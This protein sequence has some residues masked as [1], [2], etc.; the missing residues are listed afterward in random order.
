M[1]LVGARWLARLVFESGARARPVGRCAVLIAGLGAGACNLDNPGVALPAGTVAFPIGLALSGEDDAGAPRFLYVANA[2]FDLNYNA[3]SVQSYD[4]EE[5]ARRID[6][7]DGGCRP[8]AAELPPGAGEQADAGSPDAEASD[9]ALDG[10]LP[11]SELPDAEVDGDLP[12]GDVPDAELDA[13]VDSSVAIVDAQTPT[14]DLAASTRTNLCDGRRRSD[15]KISAPDDES[16]CCFGGRDTLSQLR[17]SEVPIDSF[18]SAI[19]VSPDKK[20]V[21]VPVRSKTR[22]LYLDVNDN[23]VLSCGKADPTASAEEGPVDQGGRC[24]RGAKLGE[25]GETA[26]NGTNDEAGFPAQPTSL[27][28]GELKQLNASLSGDFVATTHE[29]GAISLFGLNDDGKP[30][31]KDVLPS[32]ADRSV[33]ITFDAVSGLF[34]VASA[35]LNTIDR[36]GLTLFDGGPMKESTPLLYRSPAVLVAGLTSAFDVRDV[37]IDAE[38]GRIFALVRG[39]GTGVI[40]S[41]VILQQGS[42]DDGRF[43]KVL[44]EVRLGRGPAKMQQAKIGDRNLVFVSCYEEGSVYVVD[45]DRRQ[46]VYEIKE[47]SGPFD[48]KIDLKRE[49]LYV[50]D[51]RASVIRVVDIQGLARQTLQP[52]PRIVA[53]IGAPYFPGAIQ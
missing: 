5:I 19:V 25:M 21:Y 29:G 26:D 17:I 22:L 45:A 7:A 42:G 49:L 1:N 24:R 38:H 3:G 9:G 12:D 2:N 14:L 20:H 35:S 15:G 30:V 50:T 51:F 40:Q 37:Q 41:L 32:S 23:G 48:M 10:G 4:L 52:T 31:L 28:V 39:T 27:A 53:T 43:A 8:L 16:I 11:D 36:V 34:Y 46:L 6:R 18:A 13:A 44:D 33:S 47:F